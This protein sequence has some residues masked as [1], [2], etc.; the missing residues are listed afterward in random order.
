MGSAK[1][2][3]AT[4]PGEVTIT[5]K[6]SNNP[7]KFTS[8]TLSGVQNLTIDNVIF[9]YT[10]ASTDLVWIAPFALG[11]GTGQLKNI[12]IRNSGFDG[13]EASGTGNAAEDGFGFAKGLA[14]DGRSST[15]ARATGIV[16]E[17][18]TFHRWHRAALFGSVDGLTV[19]NNEVYDV[20][21][22]GFDFA[23]V[24]NTVIEGNYMHDF[25]QS[26]TSLDH[27]DMIQFWTNGTTWP[28][29]NITIRGN[30]L[31]AQ[32]GDWTQSIFM[33]N[34]EVDNGRAGSEMFYRNVLI[35]NNVIHNAHLHGITLGEVDGVVVQNNT[36]LNNIDAGNPTAPLSSVHIPN[37]SMKATSLNVN[38][39]KNVI[40]GG[41]PKTQ[42][43]G[44]SDNLYVQ[45]SYPT[46]AHYYNAY[47]ANALA[48]GAVRKADLTVLPGSLVDTGNY[49]SPL[50]K[51]ASDFVYI[52]S[53][54]GAGLNS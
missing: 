49:G 33:R 35:E 29:V 15:G 20:R 6:D 39:T 48:Q 8:M 12:T 27:M 16:I 42:P 53:T 18:N 2:P 4:F 43:A 17:N 50:L 25:R 7:A 21:S 14:V 3:F 38:V 52:S 19:R 28:N 32:D 46:Q 24:Q 40:A 1:Q 41:K 31:M 37:I 54:A 22:D 26:A 44:F 23:A 45:Q 10:Y 34:E 9:D 13:D 51:P 5:S 47:F 11:N 36:L 30:W